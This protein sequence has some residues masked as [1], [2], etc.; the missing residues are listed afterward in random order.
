MSFL[1]L[2]DSDLNKLPIKREARCPFPSSRSSDQP[3]SIESYY[4]SSSTRKATMGRVTSKLPLLGILLVVLLLLPCT[5]VAAVAKA[6]DASNNQ[7]LDLPDALVGPESVAFDSHGAGP[8]ISIS[9]GRILKYG[10]EGAGWSTFTYSPSYTKNNC[11][12]PSELP[13]VAS[14]YSPV[15]GVGDG[16]GEQVRYYLYRVIEIS[17]LTVG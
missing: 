9:D 14:C 8:Y 13:P 3:A 15:D 10:G 12:A 5:A 11:D 16:G 6:I 4:S 7:R 2:I 1:F 17:S